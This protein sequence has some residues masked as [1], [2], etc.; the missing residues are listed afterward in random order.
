MTDRPQHDASMPPFV[1]A[2]LG[3]MGIAI[4]VVSVRSVL[5]PNGRFRIRRQLDLDCMGDLA[6]S[7]TGVPKRRLGRANSTTCL[8]LLNASLREGGTHLRLP[9]GSLVSAIAASHPVVCKPSPAQ[10]PAGGPADHDS[11]HAGS[12]VWASHHIHCDPRHHVV[13]PDLRLVE[14]CGMAAPVQCFAQRVSSV[15]AEAGSRPI[16]PPVEKNCY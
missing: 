2:T 6:R 11:S 3:T 13:A 9:R 4:M 7:H 1:I 12:G 5:R 15:V 14:H 8:L 10:I 16:G